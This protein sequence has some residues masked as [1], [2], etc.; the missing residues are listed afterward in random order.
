MK[1]KIIDSIMGSGKTSAAINYMNKD[2]QK[3]FIYIT[4]YLDEVDRVISACNE[5]RDFGLCSY[6]DDKGN[7]VT[8]ESIINGFY[9][10][11]LS[12][13]SKK[14]TLKSLIKKEKCIATTHSMFNQF[15]D[16][17]MELIASKGYELILDEAANV[18]SP[19]GELKKSDKDILFNNFLRVGDKGIVEWIDNDYDGKFNEVKH[20]CNLGSL[21]CYGEKTL[22]LWL[23]PIKAFACFDKVT[24]LTYMFEGQLQKYY[25]DLYDVDYDYGIACKD[26]DGNYIFKDIDVPPETKLDKSLFDILEAEKMNRIGVG[27]RFLSKG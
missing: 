6:M 11:D 23:M 13:G 7:C 10:P 19:Y 9:Q 26:E 21:C 25:Y 4:P 3:K 5:E 16:E 15:D 27:E 14:R 20:L 1:I 22:M 12:K 8:E 18:V 2:Y 17:I 24:I